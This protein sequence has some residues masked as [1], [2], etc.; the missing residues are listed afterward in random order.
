M[1]RVLL[2]IYFL[3][4]VVVRLLL[5]LKDYAGDGGNGGANGDYAINGNSLITWVN[6][7]TIYGTIV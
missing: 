5:Q 7:G 6:T 3:Q 4:V 1:V 2:F